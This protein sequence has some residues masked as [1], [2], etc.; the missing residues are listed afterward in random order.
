MVYSCVHIVLYLNFLC[1]YLLDDRLLMERRRLIFLLRRTVET[2][3]K[4]PERP[5]MRTKTYCWRALVGRRPKRKPRP[6]RQ[7]R[8]RVLRRADRR[9]STKPIC[10]KKNQ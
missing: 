3:M 5:L 7:E 9:R 1:Y 2:R 4:R 10:L 8:M 6:R